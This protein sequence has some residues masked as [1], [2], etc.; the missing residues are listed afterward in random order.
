MDRPLS[1]G[2]HFVHV[3]RVK[4]AAE[5]QGTIFLKGRVMLYLQ[6][7]HLVLLH[8]VCLGFWL[9]NYFFLFKFTLLFFW[10]K[11]VEVMRSVR[12]T[13]LSIAYSSIWEQKRLIVCF[14][15]SH[16]TLDLQTLSSFT[17]QLLEFHAGKISPCTFKRRSPKCCTGSLVICSS[18]NS[19]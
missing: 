15:I 12:W 1:F 8:W 5:V 7:S 4:L 14:W 3:I 10:F 16:I 9:L 17:E 2:S 13:P 18:Y 11:A 19:L 6:D